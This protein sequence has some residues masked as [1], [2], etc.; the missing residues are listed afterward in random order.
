V[1]EN[2]AFASK[3][4][5]PYPLLC[6]TTRAIGLAYGACDD[7]SAG[8]PRRISYVIG[9]DGRIEHAFPKVDARTHPAAVL[10]LLG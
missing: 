9:A 1:E 8:A 7:A 10:A 3:F 2:A 4:G 6:D 5:F